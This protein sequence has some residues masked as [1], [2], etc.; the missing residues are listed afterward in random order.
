MH[1]MTGLSWGSNYLPTHVLHAVIP[2]QS[3][4]LQ[5]TYQMRKKEQAMSQSYSLV[6]MSG[7]LPQYLTGV[8]YFRFGLHRNDSHLFENIVPSLLRSHQIPIGQGPQKPLT[9]HA[10]YN[11]NQWNVFQN[12]PSALLDY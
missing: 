9:I 7:I 10:C 2:I 3:C 5:Q 4:S 11:D 1:V 8:L 12:M 6:L